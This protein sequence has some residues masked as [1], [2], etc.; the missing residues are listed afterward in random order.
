MRR[1]LVILFVFT[2]ALIGI[3]VI[4]SN[5]SADG[6]GVDDVLS[7]NDLEAYYSLPESVQK[8]LAGEFLPDLVQHDFDIKTITTF[9]VAAVRAEKATFDAAQGGEESLLADEQCY[10]TGSIL[11][12]ASQIGAYT[13]SWCTA[14][15]QAVISTVALRGTGDWSYAQSVIQNT[16]YASSWVF[17]SYAP[18]YYDHCGY[19]Q[20][21]EYAAG[22]TA[23]PLYDYNCTWNEQ[24]P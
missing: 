3:G 17:M 18:G 20:I 2:T 21:E 6:P 4:G 16:D 11:S 14:Q 9:F 22:P 5:V 7:G 10:L 1:L 8:S 19:M 24:V 13:S 15:M 12:Y 23:W